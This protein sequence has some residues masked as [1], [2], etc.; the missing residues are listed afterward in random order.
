MIR[1]HKFEIK[2]SLLIGLGI[3]RRTVDHTERP[4][5]QGQRQT[6]TC[7]LMPL[8]RTENY[9]V[10]FLTVVTVEWLLW[11]RAAQCVQGVGTGG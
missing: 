4:G 6:V 11:H 8:L 9:P 2:K 1:R 3:G 7:R 10:R 5:A